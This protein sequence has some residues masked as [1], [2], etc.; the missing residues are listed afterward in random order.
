MGMIIKELSHKSHS[1]LCNTDKIPNAS[2][3]KV[4][5]LQLF[6]ARSAD[7]GKNSEVN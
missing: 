5:A 1:G 3:H 2:A 4:C 6:A 7:C